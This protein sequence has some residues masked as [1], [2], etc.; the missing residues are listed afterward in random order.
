MENIDNDNRENKGR[1]AARKTPVKKRKLSEFT[2][3]L[4]SVGGV[5]TGGEI[6]CM[7]D[8]TTRKFCDVNE[9]MR[10]I[11]ERCDAVW[12]PQPQRKLRSWAD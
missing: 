9:L 10:F 4:Q 11:E 7:W 12:Y 1:A 3:K 2:I 6:S 5:C 8:D